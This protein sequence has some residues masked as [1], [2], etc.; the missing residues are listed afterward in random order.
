MNIQA[1]KLEIM[2]LVLETNNPNILES[3]KALF[4]PNK[5]GDFWTNLSKDQKD[6]IILGINEI[7]NGEVVDYEDFMQKHR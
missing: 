3:I 5:T 1:E 6:D 4:N 7:E 2:K